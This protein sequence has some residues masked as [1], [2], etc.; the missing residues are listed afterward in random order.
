MQAKPQLNTTLSSADRT[1]EVLLAPLLFQKH[2]LAEFCECLPELLLHI[3]HDRAA[4]GHRL[5]VNA[6]T[7][8]VSEAKLNDNSNRQKKCR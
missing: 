3:H 8:F 5:F 4:P 1:R 6:P 7:S 2:S